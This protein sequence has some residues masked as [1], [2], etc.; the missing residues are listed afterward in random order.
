MRYTA[1]ET[2]VLFNGRAIRITAV[3]AEEQR[4]TGYYADDE[5][6]TAETT[7]IS[8]KDILMKIGNS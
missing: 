8:E 3:N 4:Y 2:V 1:G 7:E 5:N 6:E